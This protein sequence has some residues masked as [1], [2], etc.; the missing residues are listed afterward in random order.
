[1][2]AFKAIRTNTTNENLPSGEVMVRDLAVRPWSVVTMSHHRRDNCAS[3]RKTL[4]CY[5][6]T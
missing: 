6:D 4:G 2:N 5:G 1:M 3:G